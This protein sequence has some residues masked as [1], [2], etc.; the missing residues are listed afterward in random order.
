MKQLFYHPAVEEQ[1]ATF[2]AGNP[3]V[4]RFWNTAIPQRHG[5]FIITQHPS[6]P[7]QIDPNHV[8]RLHDRLVATMYND[9]TEEC[10]VLIVVNGDNG[11]KR[12]IRNI[13]M[14]EYLAIPG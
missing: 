11:Y 5:D 3:S 9:D 7:W 14:L 6:N 10:G 12:F 4:N 2:L 8:H 1:I 13:T